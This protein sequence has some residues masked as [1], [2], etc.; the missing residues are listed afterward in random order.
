VSFQIFFIVFLLER[1]Y[2]VR[3]ETPSQEM[4]KKKCVDLSRPMSLNVSVYGNIDYNKFRNNK[5]FVN[6]LCILF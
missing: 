2:P 4:N 5:T 6:Y 3:L 1:F